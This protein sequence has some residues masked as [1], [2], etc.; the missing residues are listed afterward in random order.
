LTAAEEMQRAGLELEPDGRAWVLRRGPVLAIIY[1][2]GAGYEPADRWCWWVR[3]TATGAIH[4]GSAE[5]A[6]GA[7]RHVLARALELAGGS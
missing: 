6:G 4:G 5:D 3:H 7:V 1:D 2:Q